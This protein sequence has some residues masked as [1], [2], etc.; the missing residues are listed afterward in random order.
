MNNNH[1]YKVNIYYKDEVVSKYYLYTNN[2]LLKY[3]AFIELFNSNNKGEFTKI[4]LINRIKDKEIANII[5][6]PDK[7]NY[8]IEGGL[9]FRV[10]FNLYG[11]A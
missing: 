4:S 10:Y 9:L 6:Q 11:E 2:L 5:Y 8:K 3:R 1:K 7:D